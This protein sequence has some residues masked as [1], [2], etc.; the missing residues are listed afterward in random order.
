MPKHHGFLRT[1]KL[2]ILPGTDGDQTWQDMIQKGRMAN[3]LETRMS[4]R[5]CL[6]NDRSDGLPVPGIV[7]SLQHQ[8]CARQNLF[9]YAGGGR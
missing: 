7:S 8:H 9:G 2:R 5:Y 4:K 1:E 3:L 6:P